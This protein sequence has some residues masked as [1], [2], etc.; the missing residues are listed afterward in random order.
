MEVG[1]DA[2]LFSSLLNMYT[3]A[4]PWGWAPGLRLCGHG[5]LLHFTLSGR[6]LR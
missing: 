5:A 3:G 4:R 2:L 1:A 6:L